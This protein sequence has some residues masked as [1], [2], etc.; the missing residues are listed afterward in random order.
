RLPAE[1]V[2]ARMGIAKLL[3]EVGQHRLDH[4]RIRRGRRLIVEVD[5]RRRPVLA[6][7]LRD[8]LRLQVHVHVTSTVVSSGSQLFRRHRLQVVMKR[9]ISSAAFFQ[10]RLTRI[11]EAAIS[12]ATPMAARTFDG[13]S[14]PEEQAAPALTAIPARSRTITWVSAGTPAR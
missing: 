14:L 8:L 5:R 3:G 12:G 6:G 10:P 2:I 11:A 4:P 9:S 1:A 7:L 13:L